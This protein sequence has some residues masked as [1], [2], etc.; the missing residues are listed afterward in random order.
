MRNNVK[1]APEAAGISI[2]LYDRT[3]SLMLE[4]V[5]YYINVQSEC[6]AI[7]KIK[8][9]CLGFLVKARKII[10][11]SGGVPAGWSPRWRQEKQEQQKTAELA[12]YEAKQK[13][14]EESMPEAEKELHARYKS[15]FVEIS[16]R[17]R[18]ELK[19]VREAAHGE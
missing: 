16:Q 4:C 18:A 10:K 17:Y 9:K 3:R 1:P 11:K 2:E 6:K 12:A 13:Q 14:K 8:F 15:I 5:R 7:Q 19:A